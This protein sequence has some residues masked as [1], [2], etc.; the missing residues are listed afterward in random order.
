MQQIPF[1]GS[2]CWQQLGF[3]ICRLQRCL[4]NF[5]PGIVRILVNWYCV[6]C[7]VQFAVLILYV[8]MVNFSFYIS[9]KEAAFS[10]LTIW[11]IHTCNQNLHL[12]TKLQCFGSFFLLIVCD[13]N[14]K[15][16]YS[17]RKKVEKELRFCRIFH[18]LSNYTFQW[19]ESLSI[20]ANVK[21]LAM[22]RHSLNVKP[23]TNAD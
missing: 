3:S 9:E 12:F 10:P 22:W 21:A 4:V 5:I 23:G 2:W 14:Q 20:A 19:G 15:D 17:A 13:K 11:T 18:L 8:D 6:T 1:H 7:F 16:N